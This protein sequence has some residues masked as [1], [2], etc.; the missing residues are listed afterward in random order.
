MA[1][2][3]H[4]TFSE[5]F[6][7]G[8]RILWT[9]YISLLL[10]SGVEMFSASSSL[11]YKATSNGDPVYRH[12]LFLVVGY[13]CVLLFQ[14]ARRSS[15]QKWGLLFYVSGII[16]L[17][18]TPFF[19]RNIQ[20]AHRDL[21]G[22]Q[23]SELLCKNGLIICLCWI[24][25][26]YYSKVDKGV[27]KSTYYWMLALIGSICLPIFFQNLSTSLIIGV[28]CFCVML[29]GGVQ[30]R[31]LNKTVAILAIGAAVA[32]GGVYA[33]HVDDANHDAERLERRDLHFLNRA[34]TWAE[35]IFEHES[36]PLWER[37]PNGKSSQELYS[38]MAI[39][40][41]YVS[42]IGRLPGNSQLRDFLPEAYSDYIFAIIFEELGVLGAATVI[43][44]YIGLLLR[45]YFI[46]R[47]CEDLFDRILMMGLAILITMQALI[48]IGVCTGAMFVTGQPLPIISR[49][50]SSIIGMSCAFGIMFA[51]SRHAEKDAQARQEEADRAGV[52]VQTGV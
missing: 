4:R 12:T 11:A 24:I 51:I 1:N 14:N 44:L 8:D 15:I 31:Y 5:T 39:A 30:C 43:L 52:S 18:L 50:G 45:A 29:L 25:S 22:I 37:D 28:T 33:V 35:R 16:M 2:S 34:H 36:T 27:P 13:A 19:G 47:K 10:I 3:K 6:M 21:L 20:G 41:S 17:G 9:I 40:N 42:P 7:K 26:L 23:P 46:A 38:H 48:H 32:I 49:G